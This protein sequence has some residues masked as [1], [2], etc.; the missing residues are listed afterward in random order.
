MGGCT[1]KEQFEVS[2]M[3][4]ENL[5]A[6]CIG[7][8]WKLLRP[9]AKLLTRARRRNHGGKKKGTEKKKKGIDTAASCGHTEVLQPEPANAAANSGKR[10]QK[11]K[12]H[13]CIRKIQ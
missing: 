13:A 11:K 7:N 9:N 3:E 4:G 12:N 1:A 2:L 6:L 8:V 10:Q 5:S